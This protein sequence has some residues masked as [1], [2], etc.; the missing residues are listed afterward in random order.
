[1][2]NPVFHALASDGL[3]STL[4]QPFNRRWRHFL[5]RT[6]CSRRGHRW[7]TCLFVSHCARCHAAAGP[8]NHRTNSH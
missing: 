4:I 2:V 7:Q 6:V 8:A 3:Y 1:M 5:R